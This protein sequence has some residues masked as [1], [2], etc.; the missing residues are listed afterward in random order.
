[1][2]VGQSR[3]HEQTH[4]TRC[5]GA[6]FAVRRQPFVDLGEFV[7]GDTDSAVGDLEQ[8]AAVDG[9]RERERHG[10]LRRGGSQCVVEEFGH[11]VDDVGYGGTEE[12]T[13]RCVSDV[14][15]L[16]VLDL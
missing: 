15:A 3:D 7:G 8:Q 16:V 11:H 10:A 2:T 6:G 9:A 4:A 13:L 1:M 12:R 5:A 14:H